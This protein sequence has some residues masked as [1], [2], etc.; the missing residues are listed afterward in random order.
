MIEQFYTVQE[1]AEFLK[2]SPESVFDLIGEHK[3]AAF[4]T[5]ERICRVSESELQRFIAAWTTERILTKKEELKC[6]K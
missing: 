6:L 1:V 5:S 3:I 4:R 2:I